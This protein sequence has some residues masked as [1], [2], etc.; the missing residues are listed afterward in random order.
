MEG[1][2]VSHKKKFAGKPTRVEQFR[3]VLA[4][5]PTS[6]TAIADRTGIVII[7]VATVLRTRPDLFVRVNPG[8]HCTTGRASVWRLATAREAK[9]LVPVEKPKCRHCCKVAATRPRGL[10]W[11]CY[12]APGVKELYPST[13]KYASRGHGNGPSSS[14]LADSP[15]TA[16]PGTAEKI[17]VMEQR[18]AAGLA[19]FHPA[20]ARYEGDPLP[21]E[22]MHRQARGLAA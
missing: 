20:D 8:D 7:Q 22:F 1:C 11:T 12:Y 10:C 21:L 5:G 4:G 9:S 19:I 2:G 18:A 17:A 14:P 6:T 16:A 3:A 15:T 13:S